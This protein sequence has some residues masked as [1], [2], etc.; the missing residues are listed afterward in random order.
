MCQLPAWGYRGEAAHTIVSTRVEPVLVLL[1]VVP[2]PD[3]KVALMKLD[4]CRHVD[5]GLR[6][7]TVK[8]MAG[9]CCMWTKTKSSKRFWEPGATPAARRLSFFWRHST[10]AM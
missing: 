7:L 5:D 9:V 4:L 10:A 8:W 6:K 3:E 2:V 1:D